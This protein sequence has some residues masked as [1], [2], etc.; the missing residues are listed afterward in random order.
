MGRLDGLRRRSKKV[1][2]YVHI[3]EKVRTDILKESDLGPALGAHGWK[4]N[5]RIA[6]HVMYFPIVPLEELRGV[7]QSLKDMSHHYAMVLNYIPV[8]W[9]LA[10]RHGTLMGVE[11]LNFLD[12]SVVARRAEL[13]LPATTSLAC[14]EIELRRAIEFSFDEFPRSCSISFRVLHVYS[15]LDPGKHIGDHWKLLEVKWEMLL[16]TRSHSSASFGACTRVVPTIQSCL[17]R[18]T[19]DVLEDW[20]NFVVQAPEAIAALQREGGEQDLKP[21]RALVERFLAK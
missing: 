5:L 12:K 1:D 2:G 19:Q 21:V 17:N 6:L 18:C 20:D 9:I 10:V 3:V 8:D 13:G 4:Q 11:V 15:W 16:G 14:N 7:D